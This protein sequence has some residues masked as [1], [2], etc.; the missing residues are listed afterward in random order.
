MKIAIIGGGITGL[1]AAYLLTK[2][3]H[4]V[5]VFEKESYLGGLAS[6]FTKKNWNWPIEK[7]YHHF[8][9]SDS[10]LLK[11][12][13]ELK[14][15][16]KLFFKKPKTSVFV[17]NKIYRFDN[18][19]SLLLFPKLNIV[20][21]LQTGA[22]TVLM[23][24]N[25]FW[26]P[27][28]NITAYDFIKKTMGL[29][30]FRLIWEPLLIS[31]FGSH[32]DSIPATWFWTRIQKRSFALG[33]FIGGTTT[34][35]NSLSSA[36]KQK[37]G[38]IRVGSEI[39]KIIRAE[40]GFEL[41]DHNKKK[42]V[43]DRIIFTVSPQKITQIYPNISLPI[44]K[45]TESLRSLGSLSLILELKETFLKD[46]TYWLNINNNNFLFVALVEHTNFI[47][48]TNYNSNTILYIGGYYPENSPLFKMN[49]EEII[50]K[51]LPYLK[52]INPDYD[53]RKLTV[54][55][56]LFKDAYAQPI[57]QLNNSQNLPA[58]QIEKDIFWGSLH[59]VYPQD[60]G[61]NYAIRLGI[62]I[63]DD[64]AFS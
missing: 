30:S 44:K 28:E 23:K 60:R 51:F 31:K 62:K 15:K 47:D 33:Y 12:I 59:H 7:Y 2:K 61:V 24:L 18:P 17:D 56:F 46:G 5:T 50:K 1:S 26:K 36:I 39:K 49:K 38:Q 10:D 53:F 34:L 8:F 6:S 55:S 14:I 37:N 11:L 22:T 29:N 43:F 19:K 20:E 57:P 63:A 21:K 54:D 13:N 27:L 52:K 32:A 40:K 45:Q 9:S 35:I 3:G 25:P 16:D 4:E 64:T 48:K 58:I 42:T 41:F